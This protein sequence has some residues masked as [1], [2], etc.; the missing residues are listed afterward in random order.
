MSVLYSVLTILSLILGLFYDFFVTAMQGDI[1][2][3]LSIL[4]F[5]LFIYLILIVHCA[6]KP[7]E[8]SFRKLVSLNSALN[9]NT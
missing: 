5:L 6:N 8:S 3:V 1:I 7:T 2:F 9:K 4:V